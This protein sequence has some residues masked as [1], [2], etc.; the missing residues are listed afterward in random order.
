MNP[1]IPSALAAAVTVAPFIHSN[2]SECG[3]VQL[4]QYQPLVSHEHCH[5]E[6]HVEP[7]QNP[8]RFSQQTGVLPG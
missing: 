2:R 1:L 6:L 7:I 5:T 8:V 4:Y 3:Y